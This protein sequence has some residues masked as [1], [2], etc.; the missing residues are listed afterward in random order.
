MSENNLSRREIIAGAG[1]L[2]IGAAF[3][4]FSLLSKAEAKGGE[5]KKWPWPYEKLDL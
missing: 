5:T 2:A 3:A 4:Q 1:T